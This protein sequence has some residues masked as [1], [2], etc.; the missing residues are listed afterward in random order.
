VAGLVFLIPLPKAPL[1]I[2]PII[3]MA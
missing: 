1:Y 2:H 3:P